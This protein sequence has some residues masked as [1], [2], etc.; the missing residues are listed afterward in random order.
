MLVLSVKLKIKNLMYFVDLQTQ[1][2][3]LFK[4]IQIGYVEV[5]FIY[6]KNFLQFQ[7]FLSYLM[8]NRNINSFL[9]I[10]S[11]IKIIILFVFV[12]L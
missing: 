11:I 8:K 1:N 3:I 5:D 6:I 12:E 9:Y 7:C 4:K 2:I 10:Y